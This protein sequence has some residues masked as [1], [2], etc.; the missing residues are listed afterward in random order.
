MIVVTGATG[1]LGSQVVERLLSR[2]PADQVG[3]SV[4]D[5]ARAAALAGR[6]VRVRQGD[7][8]EPQSLKHAFEGATSALIISAGIRGHEAAV[9]ANR[10]G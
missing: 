7:F 5:V 2:I 6:G 9:S 10:A 8:T 4:R 1:R 3:V